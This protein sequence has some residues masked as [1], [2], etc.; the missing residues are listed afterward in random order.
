M[1]RITTNDIRRI[2]PGINMHKTLISCSITGK[3][4]VFKMSI[5]GHLDQLIETRPCYWLMR[6]ESCLD[7]F[8]T[9]DAAMKAWDEF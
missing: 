7:V 6:G 2:L 9:A 4:I 5:A 8:M 1:D 3:S